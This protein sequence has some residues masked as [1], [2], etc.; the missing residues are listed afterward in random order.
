MIEFVTCSVIGLAAAL[1]TT[2]AQTQQ[3]HVH[4]MS[5]TVMPFEMSKTLH[6]FQMTDDGGILRV[7]TREAGAADQVGLIQ[8][9]LK[10]EAEEFQK[11][12]FGDPAKLHGASMPGLDDIEKGVA[13]IKVSYGMLP[14]GAEIIF[15]TADR[16]LITAIHRWFGARLS[17]H[18]ADAKAE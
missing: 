12:N 1:T 9:H 8:Q 17:E 15:A 18:G 16:H 14:I 5:H 6:V 2:Y 10:H 7:V 4:H 13:K 11:G 3:E